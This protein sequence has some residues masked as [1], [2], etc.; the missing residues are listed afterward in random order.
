MCYTKN[1]NTINNTKINVTSGSVVEVATSRGMA[2]A[3][4]SNI[5]GDKFTGFL[6]HSDDHSAVYNTMD[7]YVD[8]VI[9]VLDDRA[10][11]NKIEHEDGMD[12]LVILKEADDSFIVR[13]ASS[14]RIDR[15]HTLEGA[16]VTGVRAVNHA[17]Y[18]AEASRLKTMKPFIMGMLSE[19]LDA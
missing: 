14:N 8:E 4:V 16:F 7:A 12:A 10:V 2:N 6:V 9:N 15:V 19:M 3:I 17:G 1:M 5:E 11:V 18:T 13:L